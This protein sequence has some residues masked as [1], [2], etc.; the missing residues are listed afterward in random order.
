MNSRSRTRRQLAD[1]SN[2]PLNDIKYSQNIKNITDPVILKNS[3]KKLNVSNHT[4]NSKYG[5]RHEISDYNKLNTIKTNSVGSRTASNRSVEIY[6]DDKIYDDIY[7]SLPRKEFKT[8][9]VRTIS[10]NVSNYKTVLQNKP[11]KNSNSLVQKYKSQYQKLPI[12]VNERIE[13]YENSNLANLKRYPTSVQYSKPMHYPTVKVKTRSN[14]LNINRE[15]DICKNFK[16]SNNNSN[17]ENDQNTVNQINNKKSNSHDTG[18][19]ETNYESDTL[20]ETDSCE[21]VDDEEGYIDHEH[22]YD[23]FS[24]N[25]AKSQY[26]ISDTEY[27]REYFQS[28]LHKENTTLI[29]FAYLKKHQFYYQ[30][31]QQYAIS[32]SV[33]QYGACREYDVD[34]PKARQEIFSWMLHIQEQFSNRK[35]LPETYYLATLYF[36]RYMSQ[37]N[38]QDFVKPNQLKLLAIT[39]FFMASKYIEIDPPNLRQFC[40]EANKVEEILKLISPKNW[41]IFQKEITK[42]DVRSFEVKM[43]KSFN[44]E[45][46][47]ATCYTFL[48]FYLQNLKL[49]QPG[50]E[51]IRRLCFYLCDL[52]GINHVMLKFE[53]SLVAIAI[54]FM[55]FNFVYQR[56]TIDVKRFPYR[57]KNLEMD[58]FKR[59][60]E[61]IAE[62][63]HCHEPVEVY[64]KNVSRRP[65]ISIQILYNKWHVSLKKIS[66]DWEHAFQLNLS[67]VFEQK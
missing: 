13:M 11:L 1:I 29:N 32:D 5:N 16:D 58:N 40:D 14:S 41:S 64:C 27:D 63:A 3:K 56:C 37:I 59:I 24:I 50:T 47:N 65:N 36:D 54:I 45:L 21:T 23:I 19:C 31:Q 28:L 66:D 55:A 52:V 30:R 17:D 22:L 18:Y 6:K 33:D 62:L 60:K 48:I 10:E 53:A 51:K 26:Y 43:L 61:A 44:C 34:Y 39:S 8:K 67:N 25:K 15:N 42:S 35:I 38:E 7:K 20:S 46:S 2:L 4:T 57:E 9:N 12:P 49:N